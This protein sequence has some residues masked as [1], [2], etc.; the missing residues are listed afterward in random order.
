MHDIRV[1]I[2]GGYGFVGKKLTSLLSVNGFEVYSI[3]KQNGYD[4][5]IKDVIEGIGKFDVL[6]HLAGMSFV[7]DSYKYPELF[8]RTNF[9]TIL[10]SL[11]LC[12]KYK[13]KMVFVSSY[14]YGKPLY[15]PI[16]ESH[17]VA[18]YNPYAQT[19]LIGELLC[20]G[21]HRDFGV[22]L[23]I[24]R[25]FNIY[26][27]GQNEQFL[28][29]TIFSQILNG[30]STIELK[31]P[32]P[33]RDY[34]H[35]EDVVE[36]IL[37]AIISDI[38]Y[39]IFNICSNTSYSVREVTQIIGNNLKKPIKFIFDSFASR[40][41]EIDDTMGCNKKILNEFGWKPKLSFEGGIIKE[42]TDLGL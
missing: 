20:E 30:N 40:I 4:L 21:Y 6:V 1:I 26:G 11:E 39:G 42:I 14:V 16:D 10:N 18:A 29:P 36:A 12:K 3:D 5:T 24:L 15:L 35:I 9:L 8:Y 37:S 34:V 23:I 32:N 38:S 7:P 17:P 31:D 2:T 41:S 25:P 19:K 13:A 33:K 22:P 27:N 28:I